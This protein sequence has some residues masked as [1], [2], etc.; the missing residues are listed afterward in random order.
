MLGPVADR[1]A[2]PRGV[3]LDLQ[4]GFAC[5]GRQPWSG[6][7]V[8]LR[9]ESCWRWW[10]CLRAAFIEWCVQECEVWE[11]SAEVQSFCRLLPYHLEQA[12]R[13]LEHAEYP[14]SFRSQTTD[15]RYA[16]RRSP[17]VMATK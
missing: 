17:R 15:P 8:L 4:T 7:S 10:S 6:A 9:A 3:Q 13:S 2:F 12:L 11:D 16:L 14:R 1:A 5:R